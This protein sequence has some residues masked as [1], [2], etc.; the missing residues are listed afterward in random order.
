MSNVRD[1]QFFN[2]GD[3]SFEFR[4]DARNGTVGLIRTVQPAIVMRSSGCA[5]AN[6]SQP[7][8]NSRFEHEQ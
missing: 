6:E 7:V 1:I 8:R 3:Y 5:E 4:L 2:L